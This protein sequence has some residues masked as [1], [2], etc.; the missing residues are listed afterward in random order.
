MDVNNPVQFSEQLDYRLILSAKA[1]DSESEIEDLERQLISASATYHLTPN[2]DLVF[3]MISAFN[4]D[5]SKRFLV[6]RP[7]EDLDGDIFPVPL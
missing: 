4:T 7:F 5:R 3:T 1:K 2:T 6:A